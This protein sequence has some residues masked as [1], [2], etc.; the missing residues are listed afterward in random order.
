MRATPERKGGSPTAGAGRLHGREGNVT[1]LYKRST[2]GLVL[3]RRRAANNPNMDIGIQPATP[4]SFIDSP[5]S[6][7]YS[8]IPNTS[9]ACTSVTKQAIREANSF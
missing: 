7:D 9:V 3:Q 2:S 8:D 6:P 5:A 1:R 4:T